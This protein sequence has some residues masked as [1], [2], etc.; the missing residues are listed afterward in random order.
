MILFHGT[1]C[2]I[3]EIDLAKCTPNKDFGKGFFLYYRH[4]Q[5]GRIY[6]FAARKTVGRGCD[7]RDRILFRRILVER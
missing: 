6:G 2:D 5:T 3:N 4:T 7:H 1:N